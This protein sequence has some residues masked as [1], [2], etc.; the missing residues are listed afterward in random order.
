MISI[1][2]LHSFGRM[3][4]PVLVLASVLIHFMPAR[5]HDTLQGDLHIGHGWARASIPGSVNGAA[6]LTIDNRGGADALIAVRTPVAA[7]AEL[8]QHVIEND[9]MKMFEVP[10]IEIAAHTSVALQPGAYHIMLFGLKNALKTGEKFPL[11]L[12]FAKGGTVKVQIKV[13]SLG[14]QT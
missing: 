6:Y 3:L 10:R 1:T 11:E 2:F 12:V 14:Y 7:R 5:A 13:K 4:L 9:V 8:H